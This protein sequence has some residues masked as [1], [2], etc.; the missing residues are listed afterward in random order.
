[1]HK[2]WIFNFLKS[3]TPSHDVPYQYCSIIKRH[4]DDADVD[5]DFD[6][7][8]SLCRIL[9]SCNHFDLSTRAAPEDVSY[10]TLNLTR[11]GAAAAD[12]STRAAPEDVS[13]GTLSL[14]RG[15][16]AAAALLEVKSG[17]RRWQCDHIRALLEAVAGCSMSP[18]AAD[19]A[20][21]GPVSRIVAQITRGPIGS[22]AVASVLPRLCEG[23]SLARACVSIGTARY[24]CSRAHR[25]AP[26]TGASPPPST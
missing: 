7:T 3:N 15:G 1:M 9:M 20:L 18:A 5:V 21:F 11:G 23:L 4:D 12:L 6:T 10:G 24:A 22:R 19:S 25:A 13:Y 2:V 17:D 8:S 16:A 14:T 26:R